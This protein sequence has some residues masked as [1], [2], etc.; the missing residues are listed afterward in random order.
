MKEIKIDEH[1]YQ[2]EAYNH[3]AQVIIKDE[4]AVVN[5]ETGDFKVKIGTLNSLTIYYS[6]VGWNIKDEKN[7]PVPIVLK[8]DFTLINYRK[9]M[10]TEDVDKL[11][12]EAAGL[13]RISKTEKKTLKE[14]SANE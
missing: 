2:L 10:P 3:G 5:P 12:V 6:L 14:P 9:Y 8:N 13:N 4:S 1:T 11:F 7:N